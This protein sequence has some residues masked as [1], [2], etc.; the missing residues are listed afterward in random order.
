MLYPSTNDCSDLF[1]NVY[2]PDAYHS[3]D[4]IYNFKKHH[5]THQ[6]KKIKYNIKAFILQNLCHCSHILLPNSNHFLFHLQNLILQSRLPLSPK[7]LIRSKNF[8]FFFFLSRLCST[9][10]VYVV[11]AAL[12]GF[13]DLSF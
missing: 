8:F 13:P 1:S 6:P 4:L 2:R 9:R 10:R 7:L 11:E 3:A 5:E 12:W